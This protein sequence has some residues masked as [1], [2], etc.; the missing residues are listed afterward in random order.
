MLEK[1]SV[2]IITENKPRCTVHFCLKGQC[3]EI[4]RLLFF[5]E[6]TS[7]GPKRHV[8]KQFRIISNIREVIRIHTWLPGEEYTSGS[9]TNTKSS[10]NIQKNSKSFPG[11]FNGNRRSCLMKKSEAINL[12]TLSL[13]PVSVLETVH[14]NFLIYINQKR[15]TQ[16]NKDYY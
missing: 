15:P 11:H 14:V 7:P 6:I 13:Q 1:A 10:S 9:I 2:Q 4:F 5:H 12:L 3:H 16:L 8:Q